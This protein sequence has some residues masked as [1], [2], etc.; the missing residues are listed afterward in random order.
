MSDDNFVESTAS[1]YEPPDAPAAPEPTQRGDAA[2]KAIL[3]RLLDELTANE[4]GVLQNEDTECLHDF[5]IAVRRTRSALGQIKG[6]FP[7]RTVQRFA[8]RFAWLGQITSQPRD[9]DVYLLGFDQLKSELA[10]PFRDS[11]E[12]LRGFLENQCNH[13]HGELTRQ[14]HSAR[15]RSLLA[16]WRKFLLT[17]CPKKPIAPRALIPIKQIADARI[18]KLFRRAIKQGSAISKQ[19]PA[20]NIHELRKIC[21]KLRY[22]LE[23]FREHYPAHDIEKPIKQ[24]KKLQNYLGDFQDVHAR[25]DLLRGI[26][27]Q[28]RKDTSV[29]TDALLALGGLLATLDHHQ[30]KLRKQFPKHFGPFASTRNRERFRAL[31]KP[32]ADNAVLVQKEAQPSDIKNDGPAV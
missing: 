29:H 25:I 31:F 30:T 15:F 21:K 9:F 22:M 14:I 13:A 18:W 26:S 28:M 24:L 19:T 2:T 6:V 17:P 3:L 4:I 23:F 5:R 11:I 8:P 7:D 1:G 12:P 10:E 27:H 20:E 32:L 16:D